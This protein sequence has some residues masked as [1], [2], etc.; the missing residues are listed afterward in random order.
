MLLAERRRLLLLG[1][2]QARRRICQRLAVLRMRV[3]RIGDGPERLIAAPTDLRAVDPFIAEEIMSGRFPLA[4]RMLEAGDDSPF[5]LQLPSKAFA[6]RL[7]SFAWLRHMRANR[8][9]EVRAQARAITASWMALHGKKHKGVAWEPH[10]TA[11]RLIAWM[12]HSPVVLHGAEAG[13]YRRFMKSLAQQR[14]YLR[15]VVSC[16]PEGETRL[17]IQ[18]ALAFASIA[19]PSSEA[20]IRKAG[21][22]LDRELER[23][24]LADGGHVSRNPRATLE[25]L[26][27]LLPLRQ[28]YINLGHDVPQKLISAI[29]RIYPALRFFRHQDGDLALFNG[30]TAT[31]ATELLSVLRYDETGGKPFKALPHTHYHRL[32]AAETTILVDT[33]RPLSLDLSR[34]AHA[35]S[36]SF[37]MSA[38]KHRFIIN[39]GSPKFAGRQ[40]RALAR[41]TA[42]HSTVSLGDTSSSRISTSR[43]SGPVMLDGVSTGG[44]ERWEDAYGN[45]WLR[46]KHDGYL[47]SFGYMH[48]REIGL[49]ANADKI[50]GRDHFFVPEPHTGST[51]RAVVATARFHIHPAIILSRLHFDTIAMEAPDGETWAFSAPGQ[52]VL[53]D[54]DIFFADVSGI[55]PSQQLVIEFPLPEVNELR[56]MMKRQD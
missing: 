43:L 47:S 5:M 11:E 23:Q 30:A 2:V 53:I 38:G 9:N 21:Q 20:V 7:H 39:A 36:L 15:N 34:T 12:S 16:L 22:R 29:D 50:K 54:E 44:V 14:R 40:Y 19:I 13:F 37:E 46:A 49:A 10:V 35:G 8:S 28:T 27:D 6:E 55:R 33:G 3:G 24:I 26:L 17:R 48:E 4:G 31:S 56:W 51:G 25:L 45:D 1:F 41:S 18:I 42:A 32:A 52:E